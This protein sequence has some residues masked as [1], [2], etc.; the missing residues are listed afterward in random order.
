MATIAI[1]DAGIAA[2]WNNDGT[3]LDFALE[4]FRLF[5]ND[6]TPSATTTEDELGTQRYPSSGHAEIT[7][8]VQISPT[9][10]EFRILLDSTV[11]ISGGAVRSVGLYLNDGS[12]GAAG[13]LFAVVVLDEDFTKSVTDGGNIG[14]T[15]RLHVPI[16]FNESLD[17]LEITHIAD[18]VPAKIVEVPD[19]EGLGA[20]SAARTHTVEADNAYEF[21]AGTLPGD[22]ELVT[23]LPFL[24]VT[25]T[26]ITATSGSTTVT[27]YST[28]GTTVDAQ[29]PT[30]GDASN[31]GLVVTGRRVRVAT[32]G[33]RYL[34]TSGAAIAN[35]SV[36]RIE[37][38]NHKD[39][40]NVYL[41]QD[42][43]I[44]AHIPID[45][46]EDQW[47]FEDYHHVGDKVIAALDGTAGV[48][49]TKSNLADVFPI[50]DASD[51]EAYGD[52]NSGDLIIQTKDDTASSSTLVIG[53][54]KRINNLTE[55]GAGTSNVILKFAN[56]G[57]PTHNMAAGDTLALYV[58]TKAALDANLGNYLSLAGGTMTGAI[59]GIKVPH[60]IEIDEIVERGS[61]VIAN[62]YITPD[63]LGKSRVYARAWGSFGYGHTGTDSVISLYDDYNLSSLVD[64]ETGD[65]TFRFEN[66][67]PNV[68]YTRIAG[69]CRNT[70][71]ATDNSE[72][73][74]PVILVMDDKSQSTANSRILDGSTR[75]H[76]IDPSDGETHL[77]IKYGSFLV[78]GSEHA[79]SLFYPTI[80]INPIQ[81]V[82]TEGTTETLG[83]NDR[84]DY[85]TATDETGTAIVRVRLGSSPEGSSQD[86]N[87]VTTVLNIV[88]PENSNV[89]VTEINESAHTSGTTPQLT[90]TGTNFNEWQT[91]KLEGTFNTS[92]NSV[93]SIEEISL[94]YQKDSSSTGTASTHNDIN[95]STIVILRPTS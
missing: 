8:T 67:M 17:A 49:L 56:T 40:Q 62:K 79:G 43:N 10:Y 48:E 71:T 6:L 30:G 28:S 65:Y 7:S 59:E 76:G 57:G 64:N 3:G 73:Y 38:T 18:P 46:D 86:D 35:D 93:D 54:A 39:A 51:Y 74:S 13:T 9:Q 50:S 92:G 52:N 61:N 4:Y 95:R 60:R 41:V 27:I 34:G 11:P 12:S 68:L 16:S 1:T 89:S 5:A 58:R 21:N 22:G 23:T 44:L 81:P 78:T 53:L 66:D 24:P 84:I 20:A 85:G 36:I 91:I 19:L 32:S 14:N 2:A 63:V 31:K 25:I 55:T 83:S 87:S 70:V 26:K 29:T 33:A 77:D 94:R 45:I 82:I 88:I 72:S 80:L 69:G 47:N 15:F 37:Y 90:F 42:L 75:F